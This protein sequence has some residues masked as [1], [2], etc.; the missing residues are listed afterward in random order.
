MGKT[1]YCPDELYINITA[2]T[3][4]VTK[5]LVSCWLFSASWVALSLL[6]SAL[7]PSPD[8]SPGCSWTLGFASVCD[9]MTC[10]LEAIEVCWDGTV[11]TIKEKKKTCMPANSTV[12]INQKGN[13]IKQ[14]NNKYSLQHSGNK[15]LNHFFNIRVYTCSERHNRTAS[16]PFE[17]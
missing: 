1:L 9:L 3:C 4:C 8:L 7:F 16:W 10:W 15:Q 12:Q 13:T 2:C 5:S 6:A 17:C 11:A 14:I